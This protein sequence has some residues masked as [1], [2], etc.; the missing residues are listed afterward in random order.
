MAK[1]DKG[2]PR[3]VVWLI[4]FVGAIWAGSLVLDMV[5]PRY[6][7]P[8]TI[9]LAFMAI[10]STLLGIVAASQRDGG[11]RNDDDEDEGGS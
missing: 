4:V 11:R 1:S 6:D 8:Q 5:N 7:P 10:L 2:V 3:I 9:G